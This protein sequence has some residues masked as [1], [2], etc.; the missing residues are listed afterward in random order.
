MVIPHL[1]TESLGHGGK[2]AYKRHGI[3]SASVHHILADDHAKAVTVV[4]PAGHFY[5]DML[6]EH[7]V[8]KGF[9]CLDIIDQCFIRGSSIQTFWPVALIQ[10]THQETGCVVQAENR[11]AA[12]GFLLNGIQPHGKVTGDLI[13]IAGKLCIIK[14]RILRC[15][16]MEVFFR[17]GKDCGVNRERAGF[18]HG[19][20]RKG[21]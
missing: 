12:R 19:G 18:C 15:P 7:V 6:A 9:Q 13:C 2:I 10:C 8:A 4:I 1:I 14:E 5:L 20:D 3:G 21:Q 11:S 16:G 17:K